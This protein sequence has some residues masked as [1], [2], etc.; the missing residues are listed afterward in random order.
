ML[1]LNNIHGTT[2]FKEMLAHFGLK[3]SLGDKQ[4]RMNELYYGLYGQK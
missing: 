4:S 3:A 1:S 2:Q